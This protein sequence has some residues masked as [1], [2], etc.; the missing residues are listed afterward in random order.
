MFKDT[1]W[2]VNVLFSFKISITFEQNIVIGAG[3]NDYFF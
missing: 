1:R 2:H 3:I